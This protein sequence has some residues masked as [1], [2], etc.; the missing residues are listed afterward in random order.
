MKAVIGKV[1]KSDEL[2]PIE[3]R[4]VQSKYPFKEMEMGSHFKVTLPL[5][6]KLTSEKQDRLAQTV[7]A[8]ALKQG[9]PMGKKFIVRNFDKGVCVW[10]VQ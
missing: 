9:K 3:K 10:R 6:V 5:G 7:R 8:S 1:V 4:R 2:P